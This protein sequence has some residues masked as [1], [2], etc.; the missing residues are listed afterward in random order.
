MTQEVHLLAFGNTRSSG[1]WRHPGVDNSTAGMRRRLIEHAQTAEA[2]T[3]DALFFADGLNFGPPA[4]WAYKTTEDFEPLTTDGCIVVGDREHRSGRHRISDL[5]TPLSSCPTTTFARPP[6]RRPRRLEPGH[7]LRPRRRRQLQRQWRRR[8]RRAVRIAAK[9]SR[10]SRNC[11]TVGSR[12]HRRGPCRR[13]LQRRR[14]IHVPDHHGTYFDVS[15]PDRG[16]PLGA[17]TA[18]DL[19]GRVV[20]HRAGVRCAARRSH[21]HRPWQPRSCAGV[22][23]ADP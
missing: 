20:G 12:H 16:G 22:L 8:P 3:F 14:P 1:P 5:A 2:G 21:L 10:W 17:G 4:T 11:G 23:S 9:R 19:P 15:G 6:Q 18:G 13:N 7:Q